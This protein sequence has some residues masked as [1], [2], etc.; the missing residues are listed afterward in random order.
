MDD[1][2]KNV[3]NSVPC[4]LPSCRRIDWILRDLT[5]EYGQRM[6]YWI[7]FPKKITNDGH[8]SPA[9]TKSR[10]NNEFR[11]RNFS[12]YGDG[13][14]CGNSPDK[15]DKKTTTSNY[16]RKIPC[17]EISGFVRFFPE[18]GYL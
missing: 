15:F 5:F 2:R 8:P 10:P 4:C 12:A 9:Q 13:H 6:C 16:L 17:W 3:D 14:M 18:L 11:Q 7:E 1:E